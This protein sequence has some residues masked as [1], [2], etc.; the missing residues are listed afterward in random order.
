[1]KSRG[2]LEMSNTEGFCASLA[3]LITADVVFVRSF[4]E[5]RWGTAVAMYKRRRR[6]FTNGLN[7]NH[8][9]ERPRS[10]SVI[11][12]PDGFAESRL[13]ECPARPVAERV[14]HFTG[15]SE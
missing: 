7:T 14:S 2:F 10:I 6:F 5:K 15:A 1:M 9:F 12:F 11:P 4:A 8:E 3:A 13:P